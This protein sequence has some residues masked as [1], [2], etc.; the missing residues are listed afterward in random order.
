MARDELKEDIEREALRVLT[1]SMEV[2]WS[3]VNGAKSN[4]K[5][6]DN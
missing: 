5:Y 3:H 6:V 2:I 1:T 4:K